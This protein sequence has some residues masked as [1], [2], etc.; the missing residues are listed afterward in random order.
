MLSAQGQV[1]PRNFDDPTVNFN[2][3][4]KGSQNLLKLGNGLLC[5]A[6]AGEEVAVF[7]RL[8]HHRGFLL[9]DGGGGRL[10]RPNRLRFDVRRQGQVP[11]GQ[12]GRIRQCRKLLAGFLKKPF[13]QPFVIF[14]FRFAFHQLSIGPFRAVEVPGARV[15][16]PK[17]L[18]H[19]RQRG[20]ICGFLSDLVDELERGQVVS[21]TAP[22]LDQDFL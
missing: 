7:E 2:L 4:G 11:A 6:I 17:G 10:A 18:E 13:E 19:F 5:Q 12:L 3:F 8:F 21:F 16:V 20:L 14:V 9:T 15:G 1:F 22:N